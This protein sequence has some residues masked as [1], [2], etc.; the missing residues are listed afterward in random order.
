MKLVIN[1]RCGGYG[2]SEEAVF[3]Y[4]ELKG[5]TID[6][7]RTQWYTSY[8]VNGKDWM[9]TDI[10]R[11]DPILVQVVQKL[12]GVANGDYADL[13]IVE[14]PAGT[15]YRIREYDDGFEQLETIDS[16]HWEIAC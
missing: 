1:E 16:I 8:L 6:V 7:K 12:G 9:E 4:A 15:K 5:L 13:K 14:I 10:P 3:R 2:L 11:N